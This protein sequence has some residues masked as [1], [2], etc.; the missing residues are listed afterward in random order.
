ML[1]IATVETGTGLSIVV[2]LTV[3]TSIF[4]EYGPAKRWKTEA[5]MQ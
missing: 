2:L 3:D 4:Q 5:V 1:C